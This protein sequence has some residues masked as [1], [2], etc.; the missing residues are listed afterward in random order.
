M[1]FFF[2]INFFSDYDLEMAEQA[3]AFKGLKNKNKNKNK[4]NNKKKK[5]K[6]FPNMFFE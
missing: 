6:Y 2:F 5:K 4:K 3:K 1:L